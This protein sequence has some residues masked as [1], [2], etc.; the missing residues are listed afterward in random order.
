LHRQAKVKTTNQGQSMALDNEQVSTKLAVMESQITTLVQSSQRVE[1]LLEKFSLF[2]KTQAELLQRIIHLNERYIEVSKEVEKCAQSHT[3]ETSRLWSEVAQLK[4]TANKA[5]GIGIGS[6]A[7]L[8]I[9]ASIA[10]Y[11]LTFIFSTV[12]ESKTSIIR[13]QQQIIQLEKVIESK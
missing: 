13:Q 10:T 2:D 4:D 3:T 8:G 12:Q 7:M 6:M 11:F 5:H 9:L 1:A